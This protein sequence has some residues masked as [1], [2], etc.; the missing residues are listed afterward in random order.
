MLPTRSSAQKDGRR[1]ALSHRHR[2]GAPRPP[3]RPQASRPAIGIM[4]YGMLVNVR[5]SVSVWPVKR[6]CR[7]RTLSFGS[8]AYVSG[9]EVGERVKSLLVALFLFENVLGFALSARPRRPDA[10]SDRF[11]CCRAACWRRA[12]GPGTWRRWWNRCDADRPAAGVCPQRLR[13]A[14]L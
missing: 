6:N 5:S 13:R 3:S 11:V 9:N 10:K 7:T 2:G 14:G 1:E 8:E 4:N 12:A